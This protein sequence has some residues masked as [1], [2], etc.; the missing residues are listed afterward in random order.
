MT[1]QVVI[2]R[3]ARLALAAAVREG[4]PHEACGALIGHCRFGEHWDITQVRTLTNHAPDPERAYLIPAADVRAVE[5]YAAGQGSTVV[6]FFHSHPRGTAPSNTDL[7]SAWPGYV[8]VI[9]DAST[10]RL[11]AWTLRYGGTAFVPV[12]LCEP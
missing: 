1:E 5:R 10:A 12:E 6:G 7:H 9:G 4:R 8:Y 2:S 11:A 3:A